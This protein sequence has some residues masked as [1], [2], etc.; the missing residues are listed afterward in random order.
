MTLDAL[1]TPAAVVD[2]DRME[3][4]LDRMAAYVREHGLRLRPHAKTHKAPCIAAEQIARGAVGLTVATLREAEVMSAVTDDILVA[5]PPVGRPKL[6][7][8]FALPDRLRLS[9]ALDSA[10]ALH[11]LADAARRYGRDVDVLVELDV[12]MRRV[13]AQTA[14]DAVSLARD[15]AGRPRLDFRG[16]LFYPGHIREHVDRQAGDLARLA[17]DLHAVLDALDRAGLPAAVVSGGSTPLAW[18]AHELPGLTEVR[19]GTYVFNDRTT[20]GIGACAWDHCA[21]SILA[22]V[23]STAVP[24]QA[25]VDAGS[26]TLAREEIRADGLGGYGALLDRPDVAL[27]TV[28]EEHGVLDL[29]GTDWRPRVGDRV[30]IVPNHVCVSVNLQDRVHGVRGGAVERTWDVAARNWG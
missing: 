24:G 15:V 25:V 7:R 5:H 21:Y 1:Y 13:G 28:S 4:N 14:A 8:L 27:R 26:K 17:R 12:G 18:T 23:V 20:A 6:D 29:T 9:V 16:V 2:L 3:A 11:G 22:T 19:P 30:R 10:E